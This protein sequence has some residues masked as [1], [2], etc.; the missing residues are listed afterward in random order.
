MDLM[1]GIMCDFDSGHVKVD[2]N[3]N[4]ASDEE[5]QTSP[6]TNSWKTKPVHVARV[7][8]FK[9]HIEEPADTE[10]VAEL[11]Q[12]FLCLTRKR[13][14]VLTSVAKRYLWMVVSDKEK[15]FSDCDQCFGKL[16]A[17]AGFAYNRYL[18][19]IPSRDVND[20]FTFKRNEN[21]DDI[22][23]KDFL[24]V[25][26]SKKRNRGKESFRAGEKKMKSL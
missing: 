16:R 19:Q 20:F 18:R 21:E 25:D 23:I 6:T 10:E 11:Q 7:V 1:P 8:V 22:H 24:E 17:R 9:W 3:V 4:L 12:C 13:K 14:V 2:Y 26:R 5:N 15:Q